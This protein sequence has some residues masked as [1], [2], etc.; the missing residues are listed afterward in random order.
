MIYI[1]IIQII[2]ILGDITTLIL[3]IDISILFII[4][5]GIQDITTLIIITT[6]TI[7]IIPH[8]IHQIDITDMIAMVKEPLITLIR[9]DPAQIYHL[10]VDEVLQHQQLQQIEGQNIQILE[11]LEL[12]TQLEM[13]TLE[14][15]DNQQ[16]LILQLQEVLTQEVLQQEHELLGIQP[17]MNLEL[18]HPIIQQIEHPQ[19]IIND[20]L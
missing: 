15:L 7:I 6:H 18:E 12:I 19:L 14:H 9:E 13:Q 8:T 20:P 11:E 10:Q 3:T 2:I 16:E 5:M 1:H 17:I 4:I